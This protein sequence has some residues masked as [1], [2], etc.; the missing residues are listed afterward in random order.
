VLC[1]ASANT[2]AKLA[3]GFAEDL[4][5]AMA[6]AWPMDKKF[7]IF[8][9]MNHQMLANTATRENLEKLAARGFAVAPTQEGTLACGEEGLG[10]MLEADAIFNLLS[11]SRPR[12]HVLITGGATREPI[13]GIR[14]ISNVS[15]GQTSAALADGLSRSGFDVTF[16]H[17]VGSTKPLLA[18]PVEFSSFADLDEKLRSELAQRDFVAVIHCAAVSDY[19]PE[20]VN[21]EVK[22]KTAQELTLKLKANYKILPRLKEYSR[23]KAIRVIGFKLTLNESAKPAAKQ[24]LGEAVDAVVAN[25][26]SSVTKD[27]NRHPGTLVT[28]RSEQTFNDLHELTRILIRY[29]SGGPNDS[30][31]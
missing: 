5:G 3:G 25:E 4:V 24:M 10:R 26:W 29:I 21:S 11:E 8:P 6:L 23:N 13:D 22:L 17:G 28:G 2:L 16:L 15:T 31:S 30:L 12:G 18:N 14:F 20:A 27:R 7:W 9:A 19:T 1:P